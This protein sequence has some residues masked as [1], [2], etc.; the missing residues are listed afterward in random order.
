MPIMFR[1]HEAASRRGGRRLEFAWQNR[2]ERGETELF[3]PNALFPPGSTLIAWPGDV[4]WS[5]DE[6]RQRL[7]LRTGRAET[8]RIILSAPPP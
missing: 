3:V 5:R 6:G 1:Y 8:A 7:L 2:P 4:S